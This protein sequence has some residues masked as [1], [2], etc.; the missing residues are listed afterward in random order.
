M[1]SAP[2]VPLPETGTPI[3]TAC[4]SQAQ[5]QPSTPSAI[6]RGQRIYFCEAVCLED[7]KADPETSCLTSHSQ[8]EEN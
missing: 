2:D 8:T 5:Y 4:R 7:F 6:Y 1:S 3:L